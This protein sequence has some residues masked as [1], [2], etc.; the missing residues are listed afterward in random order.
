[1]TIALGMCCT[2]GI[3]IA[4]DSQ[5]TRPDYYKYYES[6][7]S[8]TE[9]KDWALLFGYADSPGLY[10]EAREKIARKLPNTGPTLD[11]V[12]TAC[13]EVFFGEMGGH[14]GISLQ[15]FIGISI[16]RYDIRLLV[17]DGKGLYWDDGIKFFGVGDS[18]LMK[19]LSDSLYEKPMS[20]KQ[21]ERLAVYMVAKAKQCIDHCGG[22]TTVHSLLYGGKVSGLLPEDIVRL[23]KEMESKEKVCLKQILGR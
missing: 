12:Y 20:V 9:G 8:Y 15:M 21:G 11:L 2:D 13:D 6:K 18:S 23:E 14:Y 22:D 17:F 10:K 16:P 1:M 5:I 3:V 7:V 19:Y 4:A